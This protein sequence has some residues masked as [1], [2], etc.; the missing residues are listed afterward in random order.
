MIFKDI[1]L[2]TLNNCGQD[3]GVLRQNCLSEVI[4]QIKKSCHA[5]MCKDIFHVT[6]LSY[7]LI[8]DCQTSMLEDSKETET[9][10][11]HS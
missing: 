4:L 3:Y 7:D 2:Q 11:K 5:R 10:R 9:K 6:Y 8:V 1:P